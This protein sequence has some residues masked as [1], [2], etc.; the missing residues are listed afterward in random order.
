MRTR[1]HSS[2]LAREDGGRREVV[3]AA[4]DTDP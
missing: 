4:K 2:R 3:G 1:R